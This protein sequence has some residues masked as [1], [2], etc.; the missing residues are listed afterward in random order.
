MGLLSGSKLRRDTRVTFN[1][2]TN[3]VDPNDQEGYDDVLKVSGDEFPIVERS[4]APNQGLTPRITIV[5]DAVPSSIGPATAGVA[6]ILPVH[7][8]PGYLLFDIAVITTPGGIGDPDVN[9]G[10]RV[11]DATDFPLGEGTFVVSKTVGIDPPAPTEINWGVN[12]FSTNGIGHAGD[13]ALGSRFYD[14]KT[15]DGTTVGGPAPDVIFFEFGG[16][17]VSDY[18]RHS[19][20]C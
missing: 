3:S 2:M 18:N 5:Q 6:G 8:Y 12:I 1:P 17:R 15:V 14:N 20:G 19:G 11:F 4:E 13:L 10:Y 7:L 9:Y 16:G